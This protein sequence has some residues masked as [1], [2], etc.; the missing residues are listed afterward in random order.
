M[1]PTKRNRCFAAE[2]DQQDGILLAWPNMG[3]D[4]APMIDE[5]TACY[6]E[7]TRAILED[8]DE[9]VVIVANDLEEVRQ[10]L[11]PDVDWKRIIIAVMPI[12]DTWVR[13][14]GPITVWNDGHWSLANFTFNAWG[15]KFAADCDNQVNSRLDELNIFKMPWLNYRDIVLE[16]G[17]IETD[18]NGTVMTTTCCLTAPNR[19][20]TLSREQLEQVLLKRLGCVKMLW[21][22]H[23][24]LVGD[25][26]DGHID[27]LARFAPGGVIIYTG[28]DDP[29]DEHFEPLMKMEE[30]L[31]AFTDA[32]G[33]HYHLIK[34]PLPDPIYEHGYFRLPATYANFLITNHQVLV[35]IYGQPEK[36]IQACQLIGEAFPGR[37]VVGIDCRP[38]IQEH[39][40]LHC[41]TMQLPKGALSELISNQ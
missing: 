28:C 11:G 22:D 35:P 20:D 3:T 4:W 6:V 36:D 15:M 21:L 10:A 18:G 39:G 34:L 29:A 25:D 16:G 2:W 27:T 9:R 40:S 26:T 33:N 23:G 14:Y 41:A 38:L 37:K 1:F 13:D 7:I 30:D 5:V 12:N 24:S 8:E 19:N 31:K 17:S 32:D